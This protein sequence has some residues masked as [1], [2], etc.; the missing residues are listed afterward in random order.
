MESKEKSEM[1]EEI[2]YIIRHDI[3]HVQASDSKYSNRLTAE[4]L[5]SYFSRIIEQNKAKYKYGNF[6]VSPNNCK[7]TDIGKRF[8]N[9]VFIRLNLKEIDFGI[10]CIDLLFEDI[11]SA[12]KWFNGISEKLV[13]F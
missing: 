3:N 9:R 7:S 5:E 6:E 10:G 13:N 2:K 1:Q 11:D 12:K 4:V 8:N